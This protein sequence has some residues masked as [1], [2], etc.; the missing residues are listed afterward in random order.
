M[1]SGQGPREE[2]RGWA[3]CFAAEKKEDWHA[4]FAGFTTLEDGKRYFV[5]VFKKV[6]KNGKR[7]VTVRL[8]P[9]KARP[10]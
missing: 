8:Q 3:N 9:W 1:S 7:Y 5:N 10:L 4:D 2:R 6:D